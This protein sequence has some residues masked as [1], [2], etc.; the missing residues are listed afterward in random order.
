MQ[1]VVSK[2]AAGPAPTGAEAAFPGPGRGNK[3]GERAEI[4]SLSLPPG[5]RAD[6]G[7]GAQAGAA[8]EAR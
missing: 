5:S 1:L 8:Y 2:P 6:A 3:Q 7:R 4:S